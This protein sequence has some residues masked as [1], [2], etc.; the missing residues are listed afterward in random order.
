MH[1]TLT[2]ALDSI[3]SE[4]LA[5]AGAIFVSREIKR[6]LDV[7]DEIETRAGKPKG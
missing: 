2:G 7:I 4:T 6:T 5:E 3:T 1:F